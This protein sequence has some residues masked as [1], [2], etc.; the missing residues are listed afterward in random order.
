MS[1]C[2]PIIYIMLGILLCMKIRYIP[3]V[4][5][6][7]YITAIQ[8]GKREK[9]IKIKGWKGE[10]KKEEEEEGKKELFYPKKNSHMIWKGNHLEFISFKIIYPF[11]KLFCSTCNIYE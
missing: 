5:R 3:T 10:G 7:R 6:E 9:K 11:L 8:K 2:L 1:Q 4:R